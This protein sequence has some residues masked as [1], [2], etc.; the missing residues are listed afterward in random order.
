[1]IQINL[2]PAEE[3]T[4]RRS[5]QIKRPT[6]I[7]LPLV[8]LCLGITVVVAAVVQQQAE[9]QSLLKDL[10]ACEDEIATLAPEVAL[11][12]RLAKE[13]AELDLRLSVIDQLSHMRFNAVRLVDE[14]DRAVPE[15]LWLT[16]ALMTGP[17]S[18]NIEGVTFSNLIVA[19]YMTRLER[20]PYFAN[21]N[22]TIAER[23][24]ISERDVTQFSLTVDLTPTAE[25]L[26]A[27]DN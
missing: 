10:K 12:E 13:R 4:T 26:P 2:L 18:M 11:V 15:Y 17:T 16:G 27:G 14:L 7:L 25:V 21:V 20:S 6:G 9:V 22:M 8:I 1:M 19:D 24:A 5:I 3:K 23:G